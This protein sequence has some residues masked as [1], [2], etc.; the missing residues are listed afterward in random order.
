MIFAIPMATI[1]RLDVYKSLRMGSV[2]LA[3]AAVSACSS[4]S[5]DDISFDGQYFRTKI[6]KVED[7]WERFEISVSPV[8]ASLEGAREAGRYEGVRYCVQN[9]GTS[10]IDWVSGPDAEVGTLT[11]SDDKL[12]LSGTCVF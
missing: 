3:V 5:R 12:L 6:A 8:S 10:V 4:D 9:F 1:A 7:D 11:I 2:F